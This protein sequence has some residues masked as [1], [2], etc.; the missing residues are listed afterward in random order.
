MVARAV[1]HG[2]RQDNPLAYGDT[3][4]DQPARYARTAEFMRLVRRLWTE[5]CVTFRGEH[6]SVENASITPRPYVNGQRMHPTLF[7]GGASEAADLPAGQ[8]LVQ[9]M[10]WNLS[11][12]AW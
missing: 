2:S 7:F 11:D 5:E 3:E 6:D 10:T 12:Q 8:E 4:A 9:S 1:R